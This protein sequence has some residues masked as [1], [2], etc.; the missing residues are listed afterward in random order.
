[1]TSSELVA[2]LSI[3][4]KG[5]W[6]GIMNSIHVKMPVDEEKALAALAKLKSHYVTLLDPNYPQILKEIARPPLCLFYRGQLSLVQDAGKCVSMVGSREASKYGLDMAKTL[7]KGAAQ[8]GFTVISGLA[9]GIDGAVAEASVDYGAAVAVL[10][11]GV[12]YMYPLEHSDLQKKISGAGLVLSEYPDGTHP[13]VH[14]FPARNRI[15]AG[16]SKTTILVE[17]KKRS[18]T[19]ITAAFALEFNRELG[20]VPY[21]ANEESVCNQI[22]KEGGAM[23]ESV[24][25][26]LFLLGAKILN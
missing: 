7:A 1:M 2:Y 13:S 20:A 15:I 26:L 10:G 22:I 12:D 18:G 23:V 4:N 19:M 3:V 9:K 25:D 21:H 16:L 6:N 5:D 8:N 14:T 24:D 17:A 11:N